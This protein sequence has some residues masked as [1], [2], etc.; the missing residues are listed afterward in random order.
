MAK[1]IKPYPETIYMIFDIDNDDYIKKGR[2]SSGYRIYV[3][4]NAAKKYMNSA[5]KKSYCRYTK[6]YKVSE[7][8]RIDSFKFIKDQE[9]IIC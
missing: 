3:T 7:N 9:N 2:D 4:L 5:H 6:N 1:R 8:L